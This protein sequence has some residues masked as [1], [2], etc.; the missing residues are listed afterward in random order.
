R[1]ALRRR[2]PGRSR[3]APRPRPHLEGDGRAGGGVQQG[4]W[5]PHRR[6]DHP[7]APVEGRALRLAQGGTAPM[8]VEFSV[9]EV[10][11]MANFIVDQLLDLKGLDR[12]DK[13]ALRRWRSEELRPS[14][15]TMRLMAEK[16]N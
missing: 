1:R 9:E 10:Q 14:A 4:A 6:A 7:H 12:S 3:V 16:I 8:K 2:P 5:E 11:V 13:A 15:K